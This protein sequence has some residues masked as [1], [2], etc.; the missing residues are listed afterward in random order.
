MGVKLKLVSI[1]AIV[2]LVAAGFMSWTDTGSGPGWDSI[3]DERDCQPEASER[4]VLFE[5]KW[6]PW[7]AHDHF[8]M[9]VLVNGNKVGR[10]DMT[11]RRSPMRRTHTVQAG[12]SVGMVVYQPALTDEA[13]EDG[14]DIT[15]TIKNKVSGVMYDSRTSFVGGSVQ[16]FGVVH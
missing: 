16:C 11:G 4:C 12:S 14:Y 2:G 5:S 7:R 1:T 6:S 13:P 9:E 10:L 8:K 15:C 3:T